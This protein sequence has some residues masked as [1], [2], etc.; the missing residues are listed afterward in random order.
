MQVEGG[1]RVE[2]RLGISIF[3]CERGSDH[4]NT[5]SHYS[6]KLGE[7]FLGSTGFS[8]ILYTWPCVCLNF[9][10]NSRLLVKEHG[11]LSPRGTINCIPSGVIVG[12]SIVMLG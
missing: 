9:N 5:K 1:T 10:S 3:Q 11:R 2:S 8:G 4:S 12:N 7:L 6:M